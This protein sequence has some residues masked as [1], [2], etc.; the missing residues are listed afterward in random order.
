M[1]ILL[2][3]PKLSSGEIKAVKEMFDGS[4]YHFNEKYKSLERRKAQ[5]EESK[6]LCHPRWAQGM[7]NYLDSIQYILRMYYMV[8]CESITQGVKYEL[9]SAA[10]QL[11]TEGLSNEFS[12]VFSGA[13]EIAARNHQER[14]RQIQERIKGFHTSSHRVLA[15]GEGSSPK[16]RG[17][18]SGKKDNVARS[19]NKSQQSID[20]TFDSFRKA[21]ST[22]RKRRGQNRGIRR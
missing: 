5:I 17:K 9:K 13:G 11:S 12:Q 1:A 2:L 20:G 10:D 22:L 3:H 18:K 8:Y 6:H 16:N 7:I 15:R 14:I 19:T 4:L 21:K